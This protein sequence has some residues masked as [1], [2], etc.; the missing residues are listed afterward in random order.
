M[1]GLDITIRPATAKDVPAMMKL[2]H[3]LAEFEK[4]PQEV[5]NT[6]E[7]MLEEGF[8]Q[9]PAF[10]A[11]VAEIEGVVCGMS[12]FYYS[13][14]TWKGKSIYIDD[15]IVAEHFRGNGVGRAL[16]EA[17]IQ[18]A[19]EEGVGKL[20][21]Q[22]LDWN[23]PAIKFYQKYHPSFDSEWINCAISKDNLASF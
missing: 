21:W 23:E 4:A 10:R 5:L 22:V 3:E 11:L 2:V 15:I 6:E 18:I 9:N 13:Y 14:S 16:I 12:L 8:G 19:K 20:H 17:T 7:Q 1:K